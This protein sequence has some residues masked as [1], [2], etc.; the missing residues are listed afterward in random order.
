VQTLVILP[1][2]VASIVLVVKNSLA[3][4][5]S[6]AGIVAGVRFRQKLDEA[7]EAVYVLLALGIGLAAGVHSFDT[8]FV[9]SLVFTLVVM[10]FW[11]YDIGDIFA[12]GRGAQLAIGDP[13]LLQS[14][15]E[16]DEIDAGGLKANG[17]LVVSTT[18]PNG[19]RQALEVV[20]GRMAKRWKIGEAVAPRGWGPSRISIPIE[21]K[22]K[23]EPSDLIAELEARMPNQLSA[24]EY[25]PIGNPKDID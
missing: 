5:F 13:I 23:C 19:A 2:V 11:R 24:A 17:M 7:E 14:R 8:A 25:I 18:D 6:L 9:M 3:L 12:G 15:R 4:A 22:D 21:L 16:S 10:T 20:L 1:I